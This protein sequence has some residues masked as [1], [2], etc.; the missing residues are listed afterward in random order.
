MRIERALRRR[1]LNDLPGDF[2]TDLYRTSFGPAKSRLS[3]SMSSLKVL[4]PEQSDIDQ[5]IRLWILEAAAKFDADK[6]V[7][8]V[9]YLANVLPKWVQNLNRASYG[10]TAADHELKHQR[11]T[12]AF[13]QDHHRLPTEAELAHAL[14]VDLSTVRRNRVNLSVLSGLRHQTPLMMA[15]EGGY[16]PVGDED[17]EGDVLGDESDTLLSHALIQS[18]L[19]GKDPNPVGLLA[20]YFSTWGEWTKSDLARIGGTSV[21]SL[22]ARITEAEDAVRNAMSGVR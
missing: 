22:N 14:D 17:T 1:D 19:V 16:E 21:R 2:L 12:S 8:F 13:Q 11:A 9:G 10:R 6:G 7:P 20:I 5:L 15:D 4:V 18:T 3:A